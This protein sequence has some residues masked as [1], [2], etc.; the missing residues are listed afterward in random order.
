MINDF[1]QPEIICSSLSKIQGTL[2]NRLI[3]KNLNIYFESI[4]SFKEED[5]TFSALFDIKTF[6][7]K[8]LLINDIVYLHKICNNHISITG[9]INYK[10]SILNLL[11]S[12]TII[13]FYLNS[14][15]TSNELQTTFINECVALI[16]N[17]LIS[18]IYLLMRK[19]II[20]TQEEYNNIDE[21]INYYINMNLN[22][23]TI[24]EPPDFID[25]IFDK[26]IFYGEY[27]LP[28]NYN[29]NQKYKSYL[30]ILKNYLTETE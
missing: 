15:N 13:L 4:L 14:F 24:T 17:L 19:N 30:S 26:N 25:E 18:L 10:Q 2:F 7:Y 29:F 9:R 22:P 12:K 28:L 16:P 27:N 21:C 23:K 3:L 5:C 11:Y 6:N 8:H 20:L 1:N